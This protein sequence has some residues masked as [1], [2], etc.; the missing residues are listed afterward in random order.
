MKI[1]LFTGGFS[2]YPL[3]RAFKAAAENHYNAIEIGGFRP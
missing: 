2:R 3:E 1:A